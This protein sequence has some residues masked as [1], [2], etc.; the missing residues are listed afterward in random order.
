MGR[1]VGRTALSVASFSAT[2]RSR[3]PGLEWYLR[4][5]SLEA[6]LIELRAQASLEPIWTLSRIRV[7]WILC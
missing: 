6:L 2:R 4:E 1:L 7:S 5:C 3:A